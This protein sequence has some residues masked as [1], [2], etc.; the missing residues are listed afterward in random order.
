MKLKLHLN[1]EGPCHVGV[2]RYSDNRRSSA[3]LQEC[4][5]RILSGPQQPERAFVLGQTTCGELY[6]M[7]ASL[8]AC[9][10]EK[11]RERFV[12]V[13]TED[14]AVLTAALL[15]SLAGGPALVIPY[16][17]NVQVLAE[18]RRLTGYRFVIGNAAGALPEGVGRFLPQ[19]SGRIWAADQIC[20]SRDAEAEWLRLFT[21]GSTGAPKMWTKTIRNLLSEALAIVENYHVGPQDRLLATVSPNHIY[22]LLYA[23]LAPLLAC[24]GVAPQTPSFPGEIESAARENDATVLIS[25]PA[26][27]RA[28]NGHPFAPGALRLAFSSAGMLPAEDAVAFSRQTGVPIAEIYGSTETGGIA[29][30]VR[31][32]GESDFKPYPAIDVQIANER[33][34]VRSDYLSPDLPIQ[35]DG[36]FEVADRVAATQDGRFELLGRSDGIVKVGGRR[37]DLEAVRQALKKLPQVLDAVAIS[38][39]VVNGRENQIVAVVAG[40]TD[41]VDLQRMLMTALEPYARPRCIKVVEKIP[42]TSAGKID[43]KTIE[44]L[45]QAVA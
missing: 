16:S 15:A 40:R 8:R 10:S 21:G 25:V 42:L 3:E 18:L 30:R 27:Y 34:K 9:F 6:A 2:T 29:A 13:C 22:G 24:A 4:I 20:V 44:G 36:Y 7:A 37:V 45:F 17:F 41:A 5:A 31:A 26:H 1:A 33:L 38:L 28:L 12:C 19:A 35:E 23:I 11:V 32:A 14:K 43:R 39:P